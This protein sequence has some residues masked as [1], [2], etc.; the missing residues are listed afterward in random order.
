MSLAS[1]P[2]WVLWQHLPPVVFLFCFGACVGSF[3]NVVMYRLPTGMSV[4]TPPS[5]CPIC[6]VR[7]RFF[8][9]NL[10]ILGWFFVRGRCRAC[11]VRVPRR[12]ML[13]ELG[14]AAGFVLLYLL[15]YTTAGASLGL[16]QWVEE[17]SGPWWRVN[18]IAVTWPAFLAIA[19]LIAGLIAMLVIDARTCTIPMQIPQFVIGAAVIF[20]PLQALLPFRAAFLQSWPVPGTTSL[21]VGLAAGGVAGLIVS[22]SLL[23]LGW[24]RPSF[25][26]YGDHVKDDQPLAEYPHA[27]REMVRELIYL[28]PIIIGLTAGGLI[29]AQ[30]DAVPG[31][32]VQAAAGP[33][34]GYFAGAGIVWLLRIL[35]TLG[36]GR[37]AM[38]LGDVHLMGAVG[39]VLGPF[40]PILV[41]FIA[42]FFG[43]AWYFVERIRG[44]FVGSASR[45]MARAMPFGPHLALAAILV[46]LLRPMVDRGLEWLQ[47]PA[48][49]RGFITDVARSAVAEHAASGTLPGG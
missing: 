21:G 6:G 41:F 3:L 10:P 11:G 35:A 28:L 31:P 16:P 9:E 43:M 17:I 36:F 22:C 19:F 7:L 12:Y 37:E 20:W 13:V 5:R 25:A 23:F 42:P 38:G 40:D 45:G 24:I 29:G 8:R 4:I 14:F 27:R 48:T 34:L 15:F 33:W 47:L 18:G 44:L 30:F 39:A 46:I 1:M 26:D 2:P 32:F 49:P